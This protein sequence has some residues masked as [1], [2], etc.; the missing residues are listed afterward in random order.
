MAGT[1]WDSRSTSGRGDETGLE[2]VPKHIRRSNVK[3]QTQLPTTDPTKW[4]PRPPI[5]YRQVTH[6]KGTELN[7]RIN[8]LI[9]P[10]AFYHGNLSI[11]CSLIFIQS[12]DL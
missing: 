10:L 3:F 9:N 1:T 12:L 2:I 4:A 5:A 6:K 7:L 8:R 11:S